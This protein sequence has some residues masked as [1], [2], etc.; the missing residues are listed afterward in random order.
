MTIDRQ[1]YEAMRARLQ[2]LEDIVQLRRIEASL[3]SG[4][5][6]AV[7]LATARRL[8]IGEPCLLVWRE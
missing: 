5:T 6:E 4:E 3:A 1:E 2:E 7:P 8:I